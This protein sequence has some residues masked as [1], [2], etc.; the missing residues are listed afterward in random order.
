MVIGGGK[1]AE[2]KILSLLQAGARVRVVSPKATDRIRRLA[3]EGAITLAERQYI[4][5]DLERT[6]LVISATDDPAANASIAEEASRLNIL[7]NVVDSPPECNFIVP[8]SVIRKN[9]LISISTSGKSPALARKIRK[10]IQ[11]NYGPEYGILLEVLGC[12]RKFII[13]QAPDIEDRKRIF[14]QLADSVL[15]E[16][17]RTGDISQVIKAI[18][19]VLKPGNFPLSKL[20][21][22]IQKIITGSG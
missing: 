11:R 12:C 16:I 14:R 18:R 20:E 6:F 8:A 13:D 22:E 19:V 10:E 2:R 1:V 5:G 17:I 3:E 4:P 15:P 9:F 21:A 7:L